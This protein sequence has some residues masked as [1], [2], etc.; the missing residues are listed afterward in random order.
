MNLT[1]NHTIHGNLLVIDT[2]GVL[3]TGSHDIGKSEL[4]LSLLDRKHTLVSDDVVEIAKQN[5]KLI[6]S[7]PSLTQNMLMITG[8]GVVDV[9]QLLGERATLDHHEINLCIDLVAPNKMP[10][11]DDPL[12][13]LYHNEKVLDITVPKITFPANLGRNLPLLI[14][15]LV[16]NHRLRLTGIDVGDIFDKKCH[17]ARDKNDSKK[18]KN[19]K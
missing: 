5:G 9:S 17:S 12:K 10:P 4:T 19:N 1:Y 15:T 7:C 2:L 16:K 13:P 3:I 14:E 11:V 8:V 18:I 6:G